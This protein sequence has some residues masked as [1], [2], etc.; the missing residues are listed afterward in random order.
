LESTESISHLKRE[1]FLVI[2]YGTKK[3]VRI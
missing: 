1:R 3:G 2:V